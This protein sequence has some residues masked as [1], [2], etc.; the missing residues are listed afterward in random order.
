MQAKSRLLMVAAL[1]AGPLLWGGHAHAVPIPPG[2]TLSLS[3]GDVF[4]AHSIFF[5]GPA[6]FV[7]ATGAFTEIGPC[8]G[9]ATLSSP[10]FPLVFYT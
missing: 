8:Q 9:C 6:N 7:A 5:P 1:V 2:S 4:S 10:R 3:G